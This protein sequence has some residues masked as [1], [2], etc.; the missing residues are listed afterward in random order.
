MFNLSVMIMKDYGL[1]KVMVIETPEQYTLKY[2]DYEDIERFLNVNGLL[3]DLGEYEDLWDFL[4]SDSSPI[5]VNN[6]S[7]STLWLEDFAFEGYPLFWQKCLS[8][9]YVN[10]KEEYISVYFSW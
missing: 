6:G 1:E 5:D 10:L 7:Y 8:F 9:L 4:T 2:Y 3:N